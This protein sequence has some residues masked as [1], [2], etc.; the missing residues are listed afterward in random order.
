MAILAK[1][2]D[3][4]TPTNEELIKA[5][6]NPLV[7]PTLI[8]TIKKAMGTDISIAAIHEKTIPLYFLFIFT[9]FSP[10]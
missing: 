3:I 5:L 6:K 8:I 10:F 9:C 2:I 4:P 1:G 7:N